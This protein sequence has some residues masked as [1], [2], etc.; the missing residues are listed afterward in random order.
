MVVGNSYCENI[1]DD[2]ERE[3]ERAGVIDRHQ[4]QGLFVGWCS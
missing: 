2:Q 4:E 3:I 1:P